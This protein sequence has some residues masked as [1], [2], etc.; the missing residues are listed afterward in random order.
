MLSN[1]LA[2]RVP[3]NA[4]DSGTGARRVGRWT[5]RN[6]YARNRTGISAKVVWYQ[7]SSAETLCMNPRRL[8]RILVPF[9]ALLI[10]AACTEVVDFGVS[11]NRGTLDPALAGSWKKIGLPGEPINSTLGSDLLVFTRA[12]TSYSLQAINPVDDPTLD[13]DERAERVKDNDVRFDAKTLRLGG[14]NLLMV[15][16]GD[17]SGQG[18]IERYEIKGD[19]LEEWWLYPAAA[20]EWLEAKH[21]N[22]SGIT[23]HTDMGSFVTIE[24]LD[25]E[26]VGIL[27]E[28]LND[29]SLWI[30]A[31][32]YRKTAR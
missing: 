17:G 4:P 30:L 10:L 19:V 1:P 12:G 11:W 23:R 26:V 2:V 20:E 6:C 31:C 18:T 29:P 13:P 16:A 32:Q 28:T 14:R 25:D 27:G 7:A 15:R 24:K 22:V 21:P 5:Y 3:S 8:T 9:F